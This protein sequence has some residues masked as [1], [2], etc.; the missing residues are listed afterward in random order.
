MAYFPNAN[1]PHLEN[2]YLYDINYN[3]YRTHGVSNDE[4]ITQ[5]GGSN[6]ICFNLTALCS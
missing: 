2:C 4:L 6:S 5:Q 1:H 3:V